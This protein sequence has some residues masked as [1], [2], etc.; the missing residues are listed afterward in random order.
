[1]LKIRYHLFVIHDTK[2]STMSL[3]REDIM[4]NHFV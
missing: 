1:M 4:Q 3:L 2:E